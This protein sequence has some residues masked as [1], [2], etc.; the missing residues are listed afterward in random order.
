M[1]LKDK[2]LDKIK[3]HS[4]DGP[5]ESYL[6]REPEKGQLPINS[7]PSA[8]ELE[9]K[10]D[11]EL[12]SG[13]YLDGHQESTA[14]FD[15]YKDTF[16]QYEGHKDRLESISN[17]LKTQLES[18][19]PLFNKE[20]AL[21]ILIAIASEGGVRFSKDTFDSAYGD[22]A[23]GLL[24]KIHAFSKK[25]DNTKI[26]DTFREMLEKGYVR[27]KHDEKGFRLTVPDIGLYSGLASLIHNYKE[28]VSPGAG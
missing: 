28:P 14:F 25:G 3:P 2:I 9:K 1:S 24:V 22:L 7:Q 5:K 10:A 11:N 26:K 19:D 27:W 12:F 20:A 16:T 15:F 17:V 8:A 18:R 13:A 4:D 21:E 6:V 23:G